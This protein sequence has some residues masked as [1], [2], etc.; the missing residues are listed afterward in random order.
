M[1]KNLVELAKGERGGG[2]ERENS[3][4]VPRVEATHKVIALQTT[5]HDGIIT[6]LGDAFL[7]DLGINPVRETPHV[8][9]NLAK[10]DGARGVVANSLL[11]GLVEVAVVEEDVGVVVPAV[12]VALDGANGLQDA[13]ELLVSGQDDKGG[14]GPGL[15][16]VGGLAACEEDFVVFF[17]DFSAA[18]LAIN[19]Y[20]E[21]Y[22]VVR[23]EWLGARRPGR[24]CCR[25]WWDD[26][27]RG[28][29]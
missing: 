12:K 19:G 15:G 9:A 25:C 16:G 29:E 5:I 20:D 18:A 24:G 14:I 23:T 22:G 1:K 4:Y 8:G 17:A 28:Q 2:R 3:E 26:G 6:L 11:E 21:W 13:L 7:G 10:L 27:Q